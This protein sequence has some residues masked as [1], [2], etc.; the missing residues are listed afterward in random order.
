MAD[1]QVPTVRE[2]VRCTGITRA[3]TQ[4]KRNTCKYFKYCYQHTRS[5]LGLRIAPSNIP[6]G[7][8][9]LFTT[10]DIARNQNIAGYTGAVKTRAQ[11]DQARSA[12]A[13]E[14]NRDWIIDA[15]STQSGIARWAN[16]CRAANQRAGD[17][18]Q[19]NAKF[20]VN[21]RAKTVRLR[22]KDRMIRAGDEIYV[23]YGRAF[24]E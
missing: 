10:R 9:G 19:N 3:G 22:A 18:H 6:D 21:N 24:F 14:V 5:L 4:C 17:C 8:E 11:F 16:S 12:Y 13:F 1:E 7:G 23:S 2:C 20:V 15:V